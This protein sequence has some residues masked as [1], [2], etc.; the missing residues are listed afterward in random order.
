MKAYK[1]KSVVHSRFRVGAIVLFLSLCA[2]F[3]VS[4]VVRILTIHTRRHSS[5]LS[6]KDAPIAVLSDNIHPSLPRNANC[7]FWEC[8][9]IYGCGSHPVHEN[10]IGVY[11]YPLKNYV[12]LRTPDE[13]SAFPL[14]REYYAMLEAITH[15]EYY[16]PNP[17]DA[18]IFVPSIDMLNQ[19][20]IADPKLVGQ[21]LN[22]LPFWN[23]RA[24]GGQ[25]H[26][27]F[28]FVPGAAP[29]FNRV[30]DVPTDKSIIAGSGFD[31]WTYRAGFD[32]SLP[33][34]SPQQQR[35]RMDS[36]VH[37]EYFLVS[38]QLNIY[39]NHRFVLQNM[40][41][42][43]RDVL[44]LQKCRATVEIPSP[45]AANED[46]EGGS[47]PKQR[48]N[49]KHHSGMHDHPDSNESPQLQL[50]RDYRCAMT[51]ENAEMQLIDYPVVLSKSEFCLVIRG[52][53]LAQLNL[54]DALA[55][56]CIP[57]IVAD[58]IVLPFVEKI[59]WKLSAIQVREAELANLITI[60]LAVSEGRRRELRSYG[61][62]VYEKYFA[63]LAKIALTTLEILNER[64]FAHRTKTYAENNLP[65]NEHCV[66][67]P[68]FAPIISPRSHGFTALILTFDRV[69][70]LFQLVQKMANVASLQ[71]IIVIWNNQKKPPP[72]PTMFPKIN[73]P[74]KVIQT[75][76]NK[77]SNRFYPYEE[78]ETEAVLNIDDD[79]LM[80]TADE[81][82][83]G[84]EVWREFPDRI[85]GFPSRTHV[86]DNATMRWKYESEW[87]NQVSM[88]LTGAAFYHKYWNYLYTNSMPA[89][90]K[91]FVDEH[92]NCEDIAMNF[93]VANITN[94]P[95]I[96]VAPRKKFKCPECKNTEMLS[97]DLN[98]MMER[99]ACINRFAAVYGRMPLKSV[100]YR[101]DPVLY[102]DAFP[103]KLKRFN[104]IGSL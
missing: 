25:N 63:S 6:I 34:Y 31:S 55:S 72:H 83:F 53:R 77:L 87:T 18:C 39:E 71:K 60:L 61:R 102:K 15:S 97:A 36:A 84:Y 49:H 4:Q 70:S 76:A 23:N 92:M 7:T 86:W 85:V 30:L 1:D 38:P 42:K 14:T 33:L 89:E 48:K 13:S 27:I 95:P 10:K 80:L 88:V 41:Y 16:T 51:G 32:V 103:E 44:V 19:A 58:N 81:L 94:Q 99:T 62:F 40:A 37:R 22:T 29:H 2:V 50:D 79:I 69:G 52:V 3:F 67:N 98:H 100:E 68:L 45:A 57:V 73:K 90:I 47:Q 21:A 75:K 17:R 8:F 56:G 64:V 91:V 59:D 43:H 12:N 82:D 54:L 66:R 26:L 65:T 93:L 96:K 5:V 20:M 28:N 11:V 74:L 101:A 35:C 78:I 24:G 9:D 104:D 46:D